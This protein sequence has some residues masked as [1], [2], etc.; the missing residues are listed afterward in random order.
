MAPKSRRRSELDRGEWVFV[1]DAAEAWVL[2]KVE[3]RS[4]GDVTVLVGGERKVIKLRKDGGNV[5]DSGTSLNE[6]IENL[7]DLDSF[8]EGSILHHVRKRFQGDLIYTLVGSILVA[9]NPFKRLPIYTPEL[10]DSYRARASGGDPPPPHVFLTAARCY[11]AMVDTKQSQSVL[12]SGESG[13]GKTETTKFVLAFVARVAGRGGGAGAGKSVEEQILQSNPVLEAYGNAKTLRN[14]NSSRFGTW[15]PLQGR[16]REAY[17]IGADPEAFAT[18]TKGGCTTVDAIDDA[19][20]WDDQ[21][22][23][24]DILDF[25]KDDQRVAL[26]VVAATLHL[27]LAAFSADGDGSR[28]S[29]AA[30][31]AKAAPLLGVDAGK[32]AAA[33]TTRTEQMGRGSMVTIKLSPPAAKDAADALA[34][35]LYGR[36]FD[37][38]VVKINASISRGEGACHVG[39]LDIFGFE[40][41]KVN[42]FEQLCINYTNEK[43]Q[44]FFNDVVFGEEMKMYESEGVPHAHGLRGQRECSGGASAKDAKYGSKAINTFAQGPHKNAYFGGKDPSGRSFAVRHFAGA[45]T[46][47]TAGF[48]EKNRDTISTTLS[49]LC[50]EAAVPLV[51]R[52]F[53]E[54][55]AAEPASPASPG[56]GRKKK[57]GAKTLGAAFRAQLHGLMDA[58]KATQPHRALRQLKYSGLFEAIKIRKAGYAY[59]VPHAVFAKRYA[60]TAPRGGFDL[61]R[62]HG[63][64]LPA[65]VALTCC[66]NIL[67]DPA[68]LAALLAADGAKDAAAVMAVGKTRVFLKDALA[69]KALETRRA[70]AMESFVVLCQA[71]WRSFAARSKAGG[72]LAESRRKA[73]RDAAE[74]AGQGRRRPRDAL[75]PR[76]PRAPEPRR[77]AQ[78]PR[79]PPRGGEA[80]RGAAV[81]DYGALR[82]LDDALRPFLEAQTGPDGAP[83]ADLGKCFAG[84]PKAGEPSAHLLAHLPAP[85]A[86]EVAAAAAALYRLREGGKLLHAIADARASHDV[87]KLRRLLKRAD[88][89]DLGDCEAVASARAEFEDI[90]KRAELVEPAALPAAAEASAGLAHAAGDDRDAVVRAYKWRAMFCTWLYPRHAPPP[91]SPPADAAPATPD[92]RYSDVSGASTPEAS[93]TRRGGEDPAEALGAVVFEGL[94]VAA[95]RRAYCA[96]S[97]VDGTAAPPQIAA[98]L[99][100]PAAAWVPREGAF[101]AAPAEASDLAKSRANLKKSRAALQ[102]TNKK[103]HIVTG[104]HAARRRKSAWHP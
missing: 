98:A 38:L 22:A 82:D 28:V 103:L 61:V 15:R 77:R 62:K 104:V 102:R 88:D 7:V 47:D 25:S 48:V 99:A 27:G 2:G 65:D 41:F 49:T 60:L 43:L 71:A 63:K 96:A 66:E 72:G 80:H 9:V 94:G 37:W 34:K 36:L 13:A 11:D 39:V 21:R 23:A 64:N 40:V 18:L 19:Q 78:E 6:D 52:F 8:T 30:C 86:R 67:N 12:I 24:L 70:R 57:K 55:P 3:A 81:D 42:S 5:A 44:L 74:A 75:D 59:R 51:A 33:L 92:R 84:P 29:D 79:G 45:V 10:M 76:R 68:N 95:A 17:G 73:K 93:P 20:E 35:A 46:Y 4:A 69:Q 87:K 56:G 58:L 16:G 85:V 31:L 101:D 26:G 14:N 83:R 100:A 97:F 53:A 91:P 32:L 90:V 89:L 54:P 50:M 1:E